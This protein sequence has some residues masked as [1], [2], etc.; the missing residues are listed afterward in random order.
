M[1][2]T[3]YRA[4]PPRGGEV[5]GPPGGPG[6]GAR[7]RGCAARSVLPAQHLSRRRCGA[8][9]GAFRRR[10]V[11]VLHRGRV[12]KAWRRPT[13]PRLEA[14]YHRRRGFSRPSSGWDRVLCPSLWP[15]GRPSPPPAEPLF[16]RGDRRIGDAPEAPA[17]DP[18]SA[19]AS[20]AVSFWPFGGTPFRRPARRSG[21]SPGEVCRPGFRRNWRCVPLS[22]LL[23]Q[24]LSRRRCWS[25]AGC[26]RGGTR[27]PPDDV[28]RW[29]WSR[30]AARA[31][32]TGQLRGLPRFHLRPIDVMVS[33]GSQARPGFEEGF[34]LRCLQRLSRPHLA[35]RRCGWRH[36]RYTRGAS[37]PVLSY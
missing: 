11:T 34:P 28:C 20:C 18:G 17:R 15:P 30:E 22:V 33:H 25:N 27:V 7:G 16:R 5:G 19:E 1:S 8:T 37:L 32:S 26:R 24:H 12:W 9:P 6:V 21:A 4:A 35:T 14:Q 29:G 13:L 10:G 31:I 3:S 23:A 2:L 36:N